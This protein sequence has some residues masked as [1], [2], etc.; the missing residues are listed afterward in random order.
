[1]SAPDFLKKL[2]AN[3][4]GEKI[5]LAY[6]NIPV[7]NRLAI[8][9]MPRHIFYKKN[10]FRTVNRN[11]I[12]YQ[13]DLSDWVEWNLYFKNNINPNEKLY[14]LVKVG[15][16]V[17]DIGANIGELTLNFEKRVGANGKIFSFEP[18]PVN[19][20]KLSR[21]ISLNENLKNKITLMNLALGEKAVTAFL[22]TRDEHNL[23][24]NSIAEAGV[25]VQMKTLDHVVAENKIQQC[26]LIKIDVEGFELKVLK[27][28]TQTLQQFKP[29][30]FLELNQKLLQQQGD[31]VSSLINWLKIHNYKIVDPIISEE[32]LANGHYDIVC[33]PV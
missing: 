16:T 26:S 25:E 5:V 2:F 19:F 23:G 20:K 21:N 24:M 28:A 1:M 7:L 33:A 30:L 6:R 22:Q 32:E 29:I 15:M 8:A 18:S 9:S 4:F 14:E 10:S 27:G 13:L 31:S 11:G 12:N 3:P 17:F